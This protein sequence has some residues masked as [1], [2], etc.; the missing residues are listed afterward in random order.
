MLNKILVRIQNPK[1]IVAVVSG[2]LAILINTGLVTLA[3]ANHIIDIV[4][5][6]LA[7][8]VTVGIFGNP[9]SHLA[10]PV[11][12]ASAFV[13]LEASSPVA[14]TPLPVPEP[15]AIPYFTGGVDGAEVKVGG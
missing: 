9:E 14:V 7:V 3:N 15:V 12:V 13:P 10:Q 4:N 6:I 2:V 11:D 8:G 5:G 1:V